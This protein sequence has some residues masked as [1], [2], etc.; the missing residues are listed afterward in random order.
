MP[1]SRAVGFGIVGCGSIGRIHAAAIAAVPGAKLVAVSGR[2]AG[3]GPALADRY[4]ARWYPNYLEMVRRNDL[5][6]VNICTPSGAHLEPALAAAGNGKHVM[7]EK[8]LEVTLA[9]TD[10]MI[11]ACERAG[12]G[13][14]AIFPLRF[15][16]ASRFA[17]ETVRGGR[18]GR[19]LFG[20]ARVPWWRPQEYYD[21]GGWR[22]TWALDGGGALMN[23]AI[24]R[25]DLLQSLAGPVAQVGG[26]TGTLAHE[27]IEVED[28]AVGMLRFA[29]GALGSILASTALR[30]G[31]P[32]RV[33]LYGTRGAIELEEHAI[34][35]WK[36]EDGSQEEERDVLARFRPSGSG[37]SSDP[38]NITSEGHAAQIAD[39]VAAVREGRGPVVDGREGRR[40]IAIISAL[41]ESARRG[42]WVD[43]DTG[44]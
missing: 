18:L 32:A 26:A 11:A 4:G 36:V 23:Q 27:R 3:E 31:F 20:E 6:V 25:V 5:D 21:G 7:C 16:A 19:L 17:G 34:T 42:C 1:A 29:S 30:P 10:R 14:A 33:A 22:G 12:V 44:W 43:V 2:S 35:T 13:L 28:L 8:P 38:M 37:P 24:H 40:A 15:A 41:Y 39:M 9:R